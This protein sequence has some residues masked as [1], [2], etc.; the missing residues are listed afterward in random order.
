MKY[1]RI[2]LIILDSLG[3]GGALDAEQYGDKDA[4]TL[5]NIIDT[6][7]ISIPNLEKM[8][9]L[10]LIDKSN[11]K[12]N[13]YYARAIELSNGK[14]TLTGHLELMGIRT[15]TPAVT[16]TE[17]GFPNELISELEKLS[18][19]LVI[20]NISASGTEIIKDLGEEHIKTGSIIVYTSADSVLQIAA[21]EE[22][23]P[24]EELYKICEIARQL[25]LKDEWK[26][27]RIIARPFVG[28]NGDFMRTSNRKDYALNPPEKTVLDNLKDNNYDV[29]S[30]GKINDI[31]NGCGITKS[32]ST[33]DNLDGINKIIDTLKTDF[34]GLCFA[35]LNDFD[36][37]Y[38]HRRNP[39]GYANLIEEFDNYIP[40]ILNN[41]NDNDLLIITAD[42]GNDPTFKGSDHT[43]ENVPV[44]IYS[45]KLKEPKKLDDLKTFADI[46]S[47]IADNFKVT[48]TNIGTSFKDKLI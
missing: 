45:K 6:T 41:L 39:Q 1:K 37:K 30:I 7:N 38:G 21:H 32:I 44:L 29:I 14:D 13:S 10:N 12:T 11:I 26:V 28:Q 25:T 23:I 33:T 18:N 5:G 15:E 9:L 24:L 16:F 46:G 42:H 22:V 43:R 2:F 47:T 40:K 36:S 48:K 27:G 3:I 19:R 35:N 20:G 34:K 4:N 8:G 31:F 17:T